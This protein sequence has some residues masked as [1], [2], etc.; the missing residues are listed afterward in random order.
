MIRHGSSRKG[1]R[2]SKKGILSRSRAGQAV[3]AHHARNR[4]GR[5]V[6]QIKKRMWKSALSRVKRLRDQGRLSKPVVKKE[7]GQVAWRF[8]SAHETDVAD[9]S[10]EDDIACDVSGSFGI[11]PVN[12]TTQVG[13]S[14]PTG[15]DD[16]ALKTRFAASAKV[17][18]ESQE[19]RRIA[20]RSLSDTKVAKK[21]ATDIS[22]EIKRL[23]KQAEK[24]GQ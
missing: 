13:A 10:D 20:K 14:V 2:K 8:S 9:R 22:R 19:V 6:L 17:V 4:I 3:A 5:V 23:R 21:T 18:P 1:S 24:L 15:G 7:V 11:A 12:L 16:S